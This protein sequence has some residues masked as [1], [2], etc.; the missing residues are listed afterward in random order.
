MEN[1]PKV[2]VARATPLLSDSL[3]TNGPLAD[4]RVKEWRFQLTN[5]SRVT[6]SPEAVGAL[7]EYFRM[8]LKD[9]S[10]TRMEF[11]TEKHQYV[12]TAVAPGHISCLP[13]KEGYVRRVVSIGSES[14]E[15]ILPEGKK[16]PTAVWKRVDCPACGERAGTRCRSIHGTR[17]TTD[18]HRARFELSPI[19]DDEEFVRTFR[20][21]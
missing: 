18:T 9:V 20:A 16:V 1:E 8:H 17:K 21:R 3:A 6:L 2:S 4:T 19:F 10:V 12:G 5:G 13:V 7:R 14:T 11:Y 15:T